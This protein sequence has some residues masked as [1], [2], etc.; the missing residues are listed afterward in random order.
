[1]KLCVLHETELTEQNRIK[2]KETF[3]YHKKYSYFICQLE[4][5]LGLFSQWHFVSQITNNYLFV[6]QI[7]CKCIGLN[8][9]KYKRSD[10]SWFK[11]NFKRAS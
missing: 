8:L 7:H 1:M 10:G 4:K 5:I 2:L 3:T 11:I 6:V 9:N